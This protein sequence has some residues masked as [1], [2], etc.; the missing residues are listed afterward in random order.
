MP[1][2]NRSSH[3]GMNFV[4][5]TGV[6]ENRNDPLQL[7]R[8]KVRCVGFHTDNLTDVPTD[9]LPWA[10][11]MQP[12][13]S[14][15]ISGVGQTPLGPVE[16]TWV[17]GFFRDGM[18]AQDPVIMGTI[19]GIAEDPAEANKG[20]HA[21]NGIYPRP[22]MLME[23]D[24]NRLA[25]DRMAERT[26][27]L[28]GKREG[29]RQLGAI[30][31]AVAA[32]VSS[33][34]V[35]KGGVRGTWKEPH[36]RY[37]GAEYSHDD[38]Y[39]AVPI[40][41]EGTQASTYPFNHVVE[42]E[43]GIIE[44]RD[45][46]PGSVRIHEYHPSG[47]FREIQ[48][49]GDR[50]TKIIGHNYTIV[51]NSSHVYITGDHEVTVRGDTKF[52]HQGNVTQEIDGNY[53]LNVRGDMETKIGGNDLKDVISDQSTNVKGRQISRVGLDKIETTEGE[54]EETIAKD[55]ISFVTLDDVLI[56]SKDILVQAAN[57]ASWS[58]QTKTTIF[59]GTDGLEIATPGNLKTRSTLNTTII[60]DSA[61]VAVSALRIDLN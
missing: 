59:G 2:G 15:A 48:N 45:N 49:N 58:G 12:I 20:F 18:A 40:Y 25:R 37:G 38:E 10:Y 17:I 21:P 28:R 43:Q 23:P 11:P 35:P 50:I 34:S 6:V 1:T 3:M 39:V 60:S 22:E 44:E 57:T 7:G 53:L 36:P 8:C 61:N 46:T 31:T 42:G 55:H 33:S 27:S 41:P 26:G 32:N 54:F 47:T 19:G 29:K 52:Y 16:G 14:A 9:S 5:F 30:P 4:W 13:T 24:T 51:A 56:V